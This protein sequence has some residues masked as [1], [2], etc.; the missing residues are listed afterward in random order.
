[1][2]DF[3]IGAQTLTISSTIFSSCSYEQYHDCNQCNIYLSVEDKKDE[4]GRILKNRYE[5]SMRPNLI[6]LYDTNDYK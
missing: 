1:M 3:S 5:M 6:V 2:S 4:K